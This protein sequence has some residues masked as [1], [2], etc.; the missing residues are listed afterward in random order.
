MMGKYISRNIILEL[1]YGIKHVPLTLPYPCPCS[2]CH[3]LPATG[4]R[5]MMMQPPGMPMGMGMPGGMGFGPGAMRPPM[6][7]LPSAR[8]MGLMTPGGKPGGEHA[9]VHAQLSVQIHVEQQLAMVH[10]QAALGDQWAGK[11][12]VRG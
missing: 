11:G 9:L 8:P 6:P 2:P 4:M 12:I 3:G 10:R 1:C 7:T 5:P